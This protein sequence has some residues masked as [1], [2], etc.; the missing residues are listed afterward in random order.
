MWKPGFW[1]APAGL[2]VRGTVAPCVNS[3]VLATSR[4][5][6]IL[7]A[8][9]PRRPRSGRECQVVG[10]TWA[11]SLCL[12][13]A[14]GFPSCLSSLFVPCMKGA[15]RIEWVRAHVLWHPCLGWV[16]WSSSQQH[17]F[18]RMLCWRCFHVRAVHVQLPLETSMATDSWDCEGAAGFLY[19]F[20]LTALLTWSPGTD[21]TQVRDSEQQDLGWLLPFEPTTPSRPKLQMAL[22]TI[23]AHSSAHLFTFY[24]LVCFAFEPW[25]F[26]IYFE[27]ELLMWYM[28]C[29]FSVG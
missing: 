28:L 25:N 5:H 2:C 11:R 18:P 12:F 19:T 20:A 10:E 8:T 9:W 23:F 7:T 13:R 29:N 4:G 21:Q 24:F 14:C 27:Y 3:P 22:I 15:L 17:P 6:R 16:S 1:S 26:L